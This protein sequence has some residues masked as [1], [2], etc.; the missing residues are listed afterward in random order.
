MKEIKELMDQ[1][2]VEAVVEA[3]RGL[4]STHVPKT[5]TPLVD[6]D[7]LQATI[8]QLDTG[9]ADI[10]EA[11]TLVEATYQNK[12]ELLKQSRQLDTE[13]QLEE[14]HAIMSITGTGKDAYAILDNGTKVAITNDTARDAFRR[15]ASKDYRNKQSAIDA[16]VVKIDIELAKAKDAYS[17]KLEALQCIRAKANLQANILANM[18]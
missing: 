14:A 17:A 4:T 6:E 7:K 9:V 3:V 11:G 16:D 10:L 8:Y 15:M 1:Y 2:G 12:A 5:A 13:I 18:V